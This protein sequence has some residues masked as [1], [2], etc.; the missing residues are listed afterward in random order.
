[1]PKKAY[2]CPMLTR[3]RILIATIALCIVA[4][5][6]QH[7]ATDTHIFDT[8]AYAPQQASGFVI[9]CDKDHNTIIRVTRP[10]Q[11]KAPVEQSLAI[12]NTQEAAV[13]YNGQYIVGHAKRVVCMSSS[14][15]A[16]LDAIG[17]S[18]AIVGVSGKQYI[19]NK[20]ISHNPNIKD[21]GYDS[22]IDYEALLT[23]RPDIVLMYGIT[24]EDSTVTAKLR[25]LKIPY[26]YLGDYTEQSPLGK[27]EWVIAIG[28]IVGCRAYAEQIFDDIVARYNAIKAKVINTDRPKVMFNLPYQDVWYMP[29]DDS[30][31]V[32]LI[33][34]AGGEYIYKG[35]NPSGGSRGISLEEALILVN[36]ADIW[37]N[38]SQVLS[39][40]ELRAVAPH[41]AGSE[42]VRSGRVYN[43]NRIRTEYGGSDFWES[44]IVRPDVVLS[45]LASIVKGDDNNLYYHHKL[46]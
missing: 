39:L 8:I 23:L 33:E 6:N 20:T 16:M 7:P 26:L 42:V 30:Y 32:R 28:E 45:D 15:I 5:C 3:L 29:S 4:G 24:S 21:I 37:L 18:D 11:G 1:M 35:H 22:N 46:H 43:N 36:R 13:G 27:A 14:Y 41:F 2:L 40:D 38:P 12:F 9:E 44:A 19:F 17:K 31:I 34:D 10:W 25:E